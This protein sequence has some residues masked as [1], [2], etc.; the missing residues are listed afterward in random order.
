[1]IIRDMT[2]LDW[3][4]VFDFVVRE[5]SAT[6]FHYPAWRTVVMDT[7]GADIDYLLAEEKGEVRGL[8]PLAYDKS[9]LFGRRA[10]SFP[11]TVQAGA[12]ANTE[13]LQ[14]ALLAEAIKRAEGWGADSVLFKQ[15]TPLSDT[16][17][18]ALDLTLDDSSASFV[19][20]IAESEDKRL[21]SIPRKQRAVVRK[22]LA[23]GF[24]IDEGPQ[25]LDRFYA[26]YARNV[27]RLGTP[28]FPKVLFDSLSGQF[29]HDCLIW[30]IKDREG[31]DI[32]ALMSFFFRDTVLPYYAGAAD[33]SG[34]QHAHNYMYF[35]LMNRA[36]ERGAKVF[37]FGK[38]RLGSGPA[39]YKKNWG[40][41]AKTLA[42]YSRSLKPGAVI[43][44]AGKGGYGIMSKLWA[45]LPLGLANLFGPLIAKH[46]G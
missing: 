28:V 11:F 20:P 2:P 7:C 41:E 32:A 43:P 15:G 21:M 46:L 27:H 5:S 34:M 4:S 26:L 36:S 38:S 24:A 12:V 42:Y 45:R 17:V 39:A 22:A 18:E 33:S 6:F 44:K 9:L 19:A 35:M 14:H 30:V 40:F 23:A 29:K 8:L 1:M 31:K 25:C 16:I 13:M 3:T 10:L 37:D